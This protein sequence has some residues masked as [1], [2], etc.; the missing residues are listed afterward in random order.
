MEIT[1]SASAW[2]LRQLVGK[3]NKWDLPPPLSSATEIKYHTSPLLFFFPAKT[4]EGK[5][6]EHDK[7]RTQDKVDSIIRKNEFRK[8]W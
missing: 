6:D 5:S 8:K 4:S 1:G 3:V 2:S 7:T